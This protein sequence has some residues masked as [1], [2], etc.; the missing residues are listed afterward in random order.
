MEGK[1]VVKLK[2]FFFAIVY[3]VRN[4]IVL[5]VILFALL[6]VIDWFDPVF[7]DIH[8]ADVFHALFTPACVAV[9]AAF[10]GIY[11]FFTKLF[12]KH[13]FLNGLLSVCLLLGYGWIGYEYTYVKIK[14]ELEEQYTQLAIEKAQSELEGIQAQA[15]TYEGL[16]L[17]RF[18]SD[19]VISQEVADHFAFSIVSAQPSFLLD[20]CTS[21]LIMDERY[22]FEEETAKGNENIVGFASSADMAVRLL[23]NDQTGPYI[24]L[25]MPDVIMQ[26]DDYYINT[27]AH[28]LSHLYDYQYAYSQSFLSDDPMFETLYVREGDRLNAY[29]ASTRAE[30]FAEASKYYLFYPEK[31]EASAPDTYA[32]FQELYGKEN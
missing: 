28:E 6:F 12:E 8:I 10:S 32:Y 26:P 11:T 20:K 3:G 13:R 2:Q 5:T 18:V 31:L 16:P 27:L 17:L 22:F 29:G 23:R 1:K 7:R 25:S 30:Y 15:F 21:I 24:D 19:E 4:V 14:E 9:I